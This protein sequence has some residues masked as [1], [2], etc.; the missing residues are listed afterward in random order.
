MNS[1]TNNLILKL[2]LLVN[3][4]IPVSFQI[5]TYYTHLN[6]ILSHCVVENID[7]PETFESNVAIPSVENENNVD[8][9]FNTII[10]SDNQYSFLDVILLRK[11]SLME[12][13]WI[14]MVVPKLF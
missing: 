7:I 5:N 2:V 3:L 11:K 14:S 13:I 4:Y 1:L 6:L 9:D 12:N 10:Q 8:S